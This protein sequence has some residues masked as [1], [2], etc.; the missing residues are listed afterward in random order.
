M[1]VLNSRVNKEEEQKSSS[2]AEGDAQLVPWMPEILKTPSGGK[3]KYTERTMAGY[4]CEKSNV[5]A[6]FCIC[7][8]F[9][10]FSLIYY[11]RTP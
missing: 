9:R 4:S 7:I 2:N 1:E 6:Y 10:I 5:S 8:L 11:L 3:Q